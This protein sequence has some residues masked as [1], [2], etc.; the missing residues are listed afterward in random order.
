[1]SDKKRVALGGIVHETHSF[2][3]IPTTL[4]DFELKS[5]HRGE[6]IIQAMTGTRSGIGGMIQGADGYGWQLLP[7]VYSSAMPSGIVSEQAY[8]T[9]LK[10]L[11]ARL[12]DAMP[13]DGVLLALHGAMV[14]EDSLD[15][16]SDILE[17][18]REIVGEQIPIVVE[19]DMHGNISPR[20]AELADVLVAFDENPHIDAHAR[21][22]ETTDILA[23]LMDK[24]IEATAAH[25]RVPIVLAPQFT[26]TADLPIKAVHG[27]VKE[28]E[29]EDDVICISVMAGFAYSDTPFTGASMIVA[30]NKQPDLAQAYAQELSDILMKNF[31]IESYQ[32][33]SAD[34]AVKKALASDNKP[35]ILVDSA[36]NIG[37]G[38]PGDGT[39]ALKAMLDNDVQDGTVV[40][41]DAEAVDICFKAGD[42]NNVTLAVG[43]KSDKW[44][45]T[46]VTVTGVIQNL[47]DGVFD[48]ELP[49]NH[50]ASFYGNTIDMGRTVVLRVGGVNIILTTHKTPPFDLG[51]LRAMGVIPEEQKMIA[52]KS[53]VA[54]QAAYL[55]IA[56]EIIEMDTA[57][58]CSANLDRFPY[59]HVSKP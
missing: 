53:A 38:T 32:S 10:D 58:L 51:Q 9:M 35:I 2:S 48:C 31:D 39:D 20:T 54:Y 41:A 26:G 42:G 43:G 49:D 27:R 52:V 13:V 46:P 14:T 3:E 47:S 12:A 37:G 16:E 19:L 59:Q 6:T 1:M 50:F 29:A 11:L 45:G 21:G 28:M 24:Q 15:A 17:A 44:H 36:D 22:L 33:L 34:E 57:G 56:Q 40:L 5:L 23:Q 25:V 55:P 8:Q 4:A 30:T 7:T 18:V